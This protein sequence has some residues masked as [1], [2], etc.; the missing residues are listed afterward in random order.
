MAFQRTL[1]DRFMQGA[2]NTEESR[3]VPVH[4]IRQ[5]MPDLPR[6]ECH[7]CRGGALKG[8]KDLFHSSEN[9]EVSWMPVLSTAPVRQN[10]VRSIDMPADLLRERFH[11]DVGCID[12]EPSRHRIDMAEEKKFRYPQFV[13]GTLHLNRPDFP[14][15]L[16]RVPITRTSF[17]TSETKHGDATSPLRQFTNQSG[18]EYFV[19]RMGNDDHGSI[20]LGKVFQTKRLLL[21]IKR[22]ETADEIARPFPIEN[23]IGDTLK[24]FLN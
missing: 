18:A 23:G 8:I 21:I 24:K 7:P 20:K 2:I 14:E 4:Q 9:E 19:I 5:R 6:E 22:T 1:S 16:A 3:I 13:A 12:I 17:A 11:S 10:K 15:F